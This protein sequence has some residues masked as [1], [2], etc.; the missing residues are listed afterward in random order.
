[1]QSRFEFARLDICNQKRQRCYALTIARFFCNAFFE[2][3]RIRHQYALWYRGDLRG[4]VLFGWVDLPGQANSLRRLAI[5]WEQ[6]G[7]KL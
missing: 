1:M 3:N 7:N 2:S 4:G 6:I 5:T